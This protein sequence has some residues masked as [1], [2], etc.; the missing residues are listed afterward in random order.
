MDNICHTL[1]GLAVARAGL[2]KKTSLA[3]VTAAVSANLPDIDVLVFATSVPSVAFRRGITHGL[4]AQVLLPIAFAGAM[5]WIGRRRAG[6]TVRSDGMSTERPAPASFGWLLATSYIGIFTHVFLDYLNTYGI[7]LLSPMSQQWFYG[8]AVFII[9]V[10]LWLM[11]GIGVWL[12]GRRGRF[13]LKAE[14]TQV[15]T[16][17]AEAAQAKVTRGRR[18]AV[19]ALVA[20]SIYIAAMLA[21]ARMSRA[22]VRDAWIARTGETPRALMVG[23]MPLNPF[24][25]TIIV[26]A[27]DRYFQGTFRWFPARV[28]F[29]EDPIMK[30]D[31]RP[32]VTAARRDPRIRQVL[33]WSRFPAW[34][35]REVPEGTEVRLSDMRFRGLSRG[36][37]TATTIV[38]H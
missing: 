11:L 7:R 4:P 28:S 8:D 17:R 9:D 32:E 18:P 36:G 26:D 35:T 27:G 37:F 1:V 10:W 24:R 21:S 3:T 29:D 14:A 22:I 25:R 33:I 16:T 34:E 12:A 5:W 15:R 20:A 6:P 2:Q 30:N 23:P 38:P 19:V 31:S 13:R